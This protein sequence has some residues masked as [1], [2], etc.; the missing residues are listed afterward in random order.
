VAERRTAD[1]EQAGDTTGRPA[2]PLWVTIGL[3]GEDDASIQE[4]P[5]DDALRRAVDGHPLQ[6]YILAAIQEVRGEAAS[7]DTT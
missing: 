4:Y 7:P 3:T 6:D 5:T 1:A 2:L